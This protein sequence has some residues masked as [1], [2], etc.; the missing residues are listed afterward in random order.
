MAVPDNM[1]QFRAGTF[2]NLAHKLGRV[3]VYGFETPR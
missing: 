3:A 1:R 2:E